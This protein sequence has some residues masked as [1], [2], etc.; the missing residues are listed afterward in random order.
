MELKKAQSPLMVY[1]CDCRMGGDK[2]YIELLCDRWFF[3]MLSY[4]L[5]FEYRKLL[6]FCVY[7]TKKSKLKKN[8]SIVMDLCIQLHATYMMKEEDGFVQID[9][10]KKYQCFFSVLRVCFIFIC[11]SYVFIL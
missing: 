4:L 6:Y 7:R 11:V 1:V 10:F 3:D 5:N 2:D 9:S 8:L